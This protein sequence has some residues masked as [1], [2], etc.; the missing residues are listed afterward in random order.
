LQFIV[1]THDPLCLRGL[2]N[3]EVA[4]IERTRRGRVFAR[5]DLPNV[6]GMRVDQILQS[7]YF[8][9]R[10]ALDPDIERDFE[11]MYRLKSRHKLTSRQSAALAA[12]ERKLADFQVLGSTRSERLML[13]EINRYLARERGQ[14]VPA[15]RDEMWKQA[16]QRIATR[17]KRELGVAI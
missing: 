2:R 17:L 4:L 12:L 13:S 15:R 8:G 14:P 9:L 6:E 5:T 16:Q 1:S 11:R 7:E 3:G 10:S